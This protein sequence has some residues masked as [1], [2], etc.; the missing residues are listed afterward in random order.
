MRNNQPATLTQLINELKA[1]KDRLDQAINHG[2]RDCIPSVQEDY[3]EFHQQFCDI[4]CD[5]IDLINNNMIKDIPI[6]NTE[7]VCLAFSEDD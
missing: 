2:W 7:D 3:S 4:I 1:R 6:P 5:N